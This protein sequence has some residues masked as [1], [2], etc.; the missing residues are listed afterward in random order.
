M[1]W[2]EEQLASL[3]VQ[4]GFRLRGLEMTRL[5]TFCD[6]AFAFAVT[7]LVISGEGIPGSY[8]ELIV[9]LKGIPAFAASFA[10]IAT[11]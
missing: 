11:V 2:T 7:L 6:A 1:R 8:Q 10:A 4:G 5:E 9:A 3:P